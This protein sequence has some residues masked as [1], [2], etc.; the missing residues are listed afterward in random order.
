MDDLDGPGLPSRYELRGELGTGGMGRVWRIFDRERGEEVA[1]KVLGAGPAADPDARFLFAHEFWAMS[2]GSH[3]NLVPAYDF[4]EA[5]SG[6]PYFTMKVVDGHDLASQ[7]PHAEG[8]LKGWLPGVVAALA[9]LHA[10]GLVHGDLKAE[11]VRLARNGPVYLMDLGL[12]AR[13]GAVGLPAR[14]SLA[15]LAPETIRGGVIDARTDLY[16]LGVLIFEALAGRPPFAGDAAAVVRAHLEARP[17]ALA[18]HAP[19]VSPGLAAVVARLLAKDPAGRPASAGEVLAELGFGDA[20]ADAPP[21]LGSP[22]LGRTAAQAW[23]ARALAPASPGPLALRGGPGA[24]KTRLLN[25]LRALAQLDGRPTF[26]AR[27]LGP[28]AAPYAALRPW[29]LALGGAAVPAQVRLA[30]VLARLLPE[31]GVAPA[32]PLEGTAERVRLHD[33]VATLAREAAP[34]ALWL[35]D[36]A[37]RLD[38]ESRALVAFLAGAG[39]APTGASGDW[40]W[41][42]AGA[43]VAGEPIAGESL[44]LPDL[45]DASIRAIAE[46]LLGQADLPAA[47][48]ARL[49]ALA[50]GSPGRAAEILEHWRRGGALRRVDGAWAAGP[51]EAFDL[52]GGAAALVASLDL[53]P[54]A[55]VLAQAAALVGEEGPLELLAATVGWAPARFFATLAELEGR[56]VLA[57][58]RARY[59]F[60]KPA[61]ALALAAALAAADAAP[62]HAAAAAW[63]QARTPGGPDAERPLDERAALARHRLRGATTPADARAAA[64]WAMA[65]ARGALAV[66]A[67]P[68]AEAMATHALAQADPGSPL[69]RQAHAALAL[70]DRLAGRAGEAIARYEDVLLPALRAAADPALAGELAGLGVARQMLGDYAGATAALAEALALADATG[71]APTGVRARLYLGRVGY[72][73]GDGAAARQHLGEAVARARAADLPGPLAGA[74]ALHGYLLAASGP[75]HVAAGLA[76]LDE[77]VAI[78]HARGDAVEAFEALNLRGNVALASGRFLA[79]HAAFSEGLALCRRTAMTNEAVFAHLNLGVAARELGRLAEAEAESTQALHLARAQARRFPEGA[80]LAQLGLVRALASNPAAG[81]ADLARAGAIAEDLGNRYLALAV[82]VYAAEALVAAGRPD[83]AAA[84]LDRA[85]ALARET[86]NAEHRVRLERLEVAC[87]VLRGDPAAAE[88]VA[89]LVA[90]ARQAGEAAPLAHALAWASRAQLSGGPRPAGHATPAAADAPTLLAEAVALA[91]G[92]GLAGLAAELAMLAARAADRAGDPEASLTAWQAAAEQAQAA[93]RRDLAAVAQAGQAGMGPGAART[94]LEAARALAALADGLG[95]TEQAAWLAHPDRGI[96]G[97]SGPADDARLATVCDLMTG[98]RAAPGLAPVMHEALAAFT[99]LVGAARGALLLYEDGS[100]TD[101]AFLGQ[102]EH[103][104]EGYSAGLAFKVLWSDEPLAFEDVDTDAELVGRAS[105]RALGVRSA[106]GVPLRHGAE[107][108]GVLLAMDRRPLPGLDSAARAQ[109]G[110]L[111]RQVADV[112]VAA[113]RAARAEARATAAERSL[114][115][116]MALLAQT[117]PAAAFQAV[118]TAVQAAL[119]LERVLWL[120]GEALTPTYPA[121]DARISQGVLAELATATGPLQLLDAEDTAGLAGRASVAALGLRSVLAAPGVAGGRRYGVLYADDRRLREL[122]PE[123]TAT[124]DGLAAVWASW[125]AG[126]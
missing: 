110:E 107:I 38:A 91:A 108:V 39:V 66:S 88:A 30:P 20:G 10:R 21:L 42:Q 119:G 104:A 56:D 102:D 70:V 94:R 55:L 35:I 71:D 122:P 85:Q 3:P 4:G 52:P 100:L 115:L 118:A 45:D 62:W 37:D 40:R 83:A 64:A 113:R 63:W 16:A 77:A 49:P 19:D 87:L 15:S 14:G 26:V 98:V 46:A 73:G 41:V 125:L 36:D 109:L 13:A 75:A 120:A 48:A 106:I 17:P 79:A 5:A 101:Q 27:G 124:L 78:N 80:S 86:G 31:L 69:A 90:A 58:D 121:S 92:A 99:S 44:D 9:A 7:L 68:L 53:P 12:L 103:E 65:A 34:N 2:A 123:A 89:A 23:L 29:L 32:V 105:I 111:G 6:R 96:P 114:A 74:L 126:R 57:R 117:D 60:V 97:A 61:R 43:P 54:D 50:D 72:F 24:G 93:G 33:A 47:V 76:A 81:L 28:D 11:N 22:L 25:E 18:A 1:A 112:V 51:D 84:A 59:R 67:T 82:E 116:A 95:P 8:E